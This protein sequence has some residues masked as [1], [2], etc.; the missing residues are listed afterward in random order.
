VYDF[1]TKLLERLHAQV[2]VPGKSALAQTG[3]PGILSATVRHMR[4]S[5][6][7]NS[8]YLPFADRHARRLGSSVQAF[9]LSWAG[10]AVMV[11][12]GI[13]VV[14][15]LTL[16]R[17]G[18]AGAT[19]WPLA[20][21][22]LVLLFGAV[23]TLAG[24]SSKIGASRREINLLEQRLT[25]EASASRV[26]D[27]IRRLTAP[28]SHIDATADAP[29]IDARL[30]AAAR[31]AAG[32]TTAVVFKLSD[33]HGV[34]VPS[35]WSN[36]DQGNQ[37]SQSGEVF[38]SVDGRTPGAMAARQGSAMVLSVTETDGVDLPGWAEQAGF[39]QGIVTPIMRGLDTVGV[40]Y[41]FNQSAVPPAINEI[42]Q[43]ELVVGFVS[44]LGEYSGTTRNN[45]SSRT[46]PA[47][48]A[49]PST[50]PFRVPDSRSE[51]RT[52]GMTGIEMPGFTL[53]AELE[54]LEL[55]GVS[56]SL[57]PTEFLLL[58]S[59]ASSPG[60]P[61][62][63]TELVNACWSA[64]AK[65]ADNAIDV[66]IFRLRRKLRKTNSG[67]GLIMTVRGSGYMFVPPL[68]DDPTPA[69]WTADSVVPQTAD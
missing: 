35:A 32:Y 66:A 57:S 19:N 31:M 1:T 64:N 20:G 65:P 23:A 29:G 36:W 8:S 25:T 50:Q 41:V 13:A 17:P 53:D 16:N 42:E 52:S 33:A 11:T 10:Y 51:R 49:G 27:A 67:K 18:D 55:D 26:L 37:L 7:T 39:A 3:G 24:A 4:I 46:G 38:E 54:R 68:A 48:S 22:A 5:R 40:V 9:A 58:H 62:S 15:T 21:L 45:F 69:R 61:V 34:F 63:A 14:L 60:T 47:V 12:L 6:F 59:L 56:I 2:A 30:A 28:E 44:N 43:L